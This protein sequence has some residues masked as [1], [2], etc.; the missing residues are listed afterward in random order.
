MTTRAMQ[1]EAGRE[2]DRTLVD[3][4]A[5]VERIR[6]LMA[7][8]IDELDRRRPRELERLVQQKNELLA[9]YRSRLALLRAEMAAPVAAN[10]ALIA[11]LKAAARSLAELAE[12]EQGKL[13]RLR[14]IN[15]GIVRA[16]GDQVARRNA[17]VQGYG[18]DGIMRTIT[19]N[20]R[21][22]AR[23]ASVVVNQAV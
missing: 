16:V 10:P 21:L 6:Q 11:E 9:A 20:P 7:E 13:A 23:P 15:E 14:S 3:L 1:I 2:R 8:E 22:N 17:P 4:L 5:L 19:P 12:Q 18:K